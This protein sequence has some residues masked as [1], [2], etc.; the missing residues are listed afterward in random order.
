MFRTRLQSRQL[1]ET[2]RPRTGLARTTFEGPAHPAHARTG[3]APTHAVLNPFDVYQEGE[4]VLI[5]QLGA[6]DTARLRDLPIEYG[7]SSRSASAGASREGLTSRILAGARSG[8]S[9]PSREP[10]EFDT[11][12]E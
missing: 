8:L 5:A 10:R 6:L 11:G 7:F 9:Q 12:S 2:A 4:D 1:R 3:R